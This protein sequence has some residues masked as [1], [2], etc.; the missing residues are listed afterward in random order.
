MWRETP[1][2]DIINVLMLLK[3]YFSP[4]NTVVN[5]S[6]QTNLKFHLTVISYAGVTHLFVPAPTQR[7]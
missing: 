5:P 4:A 1:D 7:R 6:K 2:V 3:Q